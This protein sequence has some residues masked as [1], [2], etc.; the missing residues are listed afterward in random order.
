MDEGVL[1]KAWFDGIIDPTAEQ[2]AFVEAVMPLLQE[3][4][5]LFM[6]QAMEGLD[7]EYT[8]ADEAAYKWVEEHA[9]ELAR[10]V[11]DTTMEMLRRELGEAWETE[12]VTD[13]A[14]RIREVFDN[15]SRY[16]SYMIA[17]TETTNTANMGSMT[18]AK[19]AGATQ[20][21]WLT[22]LDERVCPTC[23]ALNGVK[24]DIDEL[25]NGEI[26]APSRH[27]NCRCTLLFD[28]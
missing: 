21:E 17:R 24:V 22:G 27:P 5:E 7:V 18:G 8:P 19:R 1:V 6:Q 11:N 28:F 13:I 12:G 16:R 4:F 3:T 15:C 23:G 26:L 20:K 10:G 14:S 9:F 2:Q 25:F